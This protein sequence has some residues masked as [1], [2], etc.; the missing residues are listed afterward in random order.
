MFNFYQFTKKKIAVRSLSDDLN[1]MFKERLKTPLRPRK[2]GTSTSY[3][4]RI[5][6]CRRIVLMVQAI[7]RNEPTFVR[8]HQFQPRHCQMIIDFIKSKKLS[9]GSFDNWITSLNKFLRMLGRKELLSSS[10]EIRKSI[11]KPSRTRYCTKNKSIV[12]ET[13]F[14]L[15]IEVIEANHPQIAAALR[16]MMVLTL[17]FQEAICLDVIAAHEQLRSHGEIRVTKGTK[18][19]RPRTLK[20]PQV[21]AIDALKSATV[22]ANSKHHSLIPEEYELKQFLQQ[23]Y[24]VFRKFNFT[25]QFGY[26]S[27]SLR[28]F[29]LQKVFY[30][31]SG[32][33]PPIWGVGVNLKQND[34][35]IQAALKTVSEEAGH[36]DKTKAT[37]YVGSPRQYR[38]NL[39][40]SN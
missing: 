22:L 34:P 14:R 8:L 5:A 19:G 4:T 16:L 6:H 2:S 10:L 32:L 36:S 30:Q 26:N 9:T 40:I 24:R 35:A 11:S 12:D 38:K 15:K 20:F 13:V 33:P 3:G 17:R 29:V 31:V 37:A 23:A 28:H 21:G 25:K 1:F 27:H 7:R 39:K 18:N